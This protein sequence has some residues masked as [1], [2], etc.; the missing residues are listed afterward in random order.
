MVAG[1]KFL[2]KKSFNPQNLSNQERVYVRQ[3]ESKLEEERLKRRERQLT[4]ERD[5]EELARARDGDSGGQKATLRFMYDAPP[6]LADEKR[7]NNI[8]QN[9]NDVSEKKSGSEAISYDKMAGDDD[10]AAAFRRI[11]AG[12]VV[13]P[14]DDENDQMEMNRGVDMT[15]K[16]SSLILSGSNAEINS[17]EVKSE[18]SQLEKAVGKRNTSSALTYEEQIARFPQLK[19]APV[20]IKR[21]GQG[22]ETGTT[23][24]FNFKPLGAQIRNVRCMVCKVWGHSKGDRECSMSGWDPF[25]VPSTAKV[26]TIGKLPTGSDSGDKDQSDECDRKKDVSDDSVEYERRKQR[27]KEK[28]KK[29]S[30][31]NR[32]ERKHEKKDRKRKRERYEDSDDSRRQRKRS[33]SKS[34]KNDKR[35]LYERKRSRSKSYDSEYSYSSRS[36]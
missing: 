26:D 18:L 16:A 35:K 23:S 8:A 14:G 17:T 21:K 28:R 30:K 32:K 25:S 7:N 33:G 19:N 3:Q 4:I 11:L 13:N 6:G 1:L 29:E 5:A 27:K 10:A 15:D 24:N 31:R 2:S 36:R 22:G 12:E 9:N 34:R 20:A